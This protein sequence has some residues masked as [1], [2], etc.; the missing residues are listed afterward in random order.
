MGAK[1]SLKKR[2][3]QDL[4]DALFRSAMLEA[5][6]EAANESDGSS[7]MLEHAWDPS[8]CSPPFVVLPDRLT[9]R[10]QLSILT[11]DCIRGKKRYRDGQHVW[12]INW[13]NEERGTFAIVGVAT[14][15]APLQS[16]GYE[17][18]IGSNSE[19]W[20]WDIVSK[21]LWHCGKRGSYPAVGTGFQVP[22]TFFVILDMD[23]RTLSFS[24]S[25]LHLGVA[26]TDLPKQLDRPMCP[27]V[28]AIFGNCDIRMRY[29]GKGESIISNLRR[30]IAFHRATSETPSEAP[31]KASEDSR[32][33]STGTPGKDSD[34]SV[35]EASKRYQFARHKHGENVAVMYAGK[36][37]KRV[38]P[39]GSCCDG[40][41][42]TSEP[43][44]DNELFEV[45]LDSKIDRWVGSLFI[46]ATTNDSNSFS[47]FP[48]IMVDYTQGS[49][50]MWAGD[51]I[52]FNKKLTTTVKED[53]GKLTTGD[54]IGVMRKSDNSLH[55]YLNGKDIGNC[56]K[57]IPDVLYGVVD[58]Y[59]QAE[60][61]TITGGTAETQ[62]SNDD[63]ES[64]EQDHII[65]MVQMKKVIELMKL[66]FNPLLIIK[67]LYQGVL[68]PYTDTRDRAVRQRYGDHLSDIGAVPELKKFLERLDRPDLGIESEE[69]WVGIT[70]VRSIL[71][72]YSDASLKIAKEIGKC[73]LLGRFVNDL[74]RI[75]PSG[76]FGDEKQ[77]RIIDSAVNILHNCA[78]A[79]ENRQVF[80]D[81]NA[82]E[83]LAPFLK[84][85]ES[86]VVI[87]A[88]LAMSYITEDNQS[89]LL[90]ADTKTISQIQGMLVN[91]ANSPGLRGASGSCTWSALEIVS[92]IANIA[93]NEKNRANLIDAG[94]IPPLFDVI[95]K[96]DPI[97]KECSANALWL[98]ANSEPG[99]KKIRDYPGAM[100][101]LNE[102][103]KNSNKSIAAAAKRVLLRIK[104]QPMK[105]GVS[106]K[107]IPRKNCAYKETCRL[108]IKSL[109]LNDHVS[110]PRVSYESNRE[111]IL[112]RMTCCL[113]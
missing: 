1:Q 58:I 41:V 50:F 19:S 52:V 2:L 49:N 63:E 95:K 54:R 87:S 91:A 34:S 64:V 37:A 38:D 32:R 68:E 21:T 84:C 80:R 9:A 74:K 25:D 101:T 69:G 99:K 83:I 59:G 61:V 16:L 5:L 65:V 104:Q 45:R 14:P 85:E 88:L 93:V 92:G 57:T 100:A 43:L 75:G 97:D 86:E 81:I 113:K 71:W 79:T 108:F 36:K 10:R 105:Q 18:L 30:P 13:E 109:N 78:K 31:K 111:R 46:G 6:Q 39:F 62:S 29:M 42:I 4:A 112:K 26:F 55:F 53:T 107:G 96:G 12:E 22:D 66:P 60:Q 3:R 89:H 73:G 72:N 23:Q 17:P 15:K 82:V 102:L 110:F 27:V 90:D 44:K 76:A 51:Q 20:G 70:I 40:V 35:V 77:K 7:E 94:V 24:T 47:T 103:S 48:Q 8:D 106:L 11:S 67:M 33:K 98:L 56:F 28:N